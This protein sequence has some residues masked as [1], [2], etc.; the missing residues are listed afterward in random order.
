MDSGG[1]RDLLRSGRSGGLSVGCGRGGSQRAEGASLQESL[2]L[3]SGSL[4]LGDGP[5]KSEVAGK[6]LD[7]CL[8]MAACCS[9]CLLL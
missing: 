3:A 1:G 7:L 2:A 5:R 9:M 6:P 8:V 4:R